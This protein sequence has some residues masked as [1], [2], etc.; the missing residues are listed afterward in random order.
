MSLKTIFFDMGGTIDTF[1]YTKMYRIQNIHLI[2][3]CLQKVGLAPNFSDEEIV[4]S[5]SNGAKKY[6]QWNF[7]TRVELSPAKIWSRFF[8]EN[9]GISPQSI[10]PIAEELAFLYETQLYIRKMR[11]EIPSVLLQLKEMGLGLGIISNTQSRNQVPFNLEQY[12]IYEFF[13]PIVLSS[14]Y[15]RR[16]PDPAIFYY[17]ARLVNLPTSSCAYVGDKINRDI[18]G[19][20]QSG[21]RLAVQIKHEYDDGF[22]DKGAIPDAIIRNMEELIPIIK[23]DMGKAFYQSI[24]HRSSVKAIFFDAGDILY[25]RPN[26]EE[27]LKKFLA[28]VEINPHSDIESERMQLKNLAFS[29]QMGRHEYYEE[30]L[31]L[32]GITDPSLIAEGVE[33]MS[34]DDNTV[35]IING[36]PETIKKLKEKGFI[37]GI[38]TDTALPIYKKLNWFDQSGF[39][40]LWD[41]FISSKEMGLRKPEPE[42]YEKAIRQVGVCPSETI[43]VG[44]K[45]SEL[46]GAHSVGMKTVAFNFEDGASADFYIDNFCELLKV[47]IIEKER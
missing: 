9:M 23:D 27:N 1:G 37:L 12:G 20:K 24:P 14:E 42:M 33:A 17:A 16:K 35:E 4:D 41:V 43:F 28:K 19:A 40:G 10:E 30:V 15:G 45:I 6:L 25:F 26:K 13:N 5:I 38:I 44:H 2:R 29:G 32:Y 3:E 34:E 21:F 22:K 36:V 47:P 18:I 46:E 39:G 7:L 8:L 31:R 11:P